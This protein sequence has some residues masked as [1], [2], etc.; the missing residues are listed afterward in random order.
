[1]KWDVEYTDDFGDW[2][3]GLTA[4]EQESL[5]T[6]VRLLEARGPTLGFPHS[7]GINGSRHSHMRELRTQHDG[8]PLRTLYA[9][10]PR[11][12]AILLIG[13]DKTGNDRWYDV[14][15]PIADRLYDEHL[16]QLR[17]EGLI[18]G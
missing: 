10:D 2:W 16:E 12:S 9:F 18:N 15:V 7:S 17:K 4:E 11:R 6:S 1:M 8:R 14:H 3:A 5:D 13:G